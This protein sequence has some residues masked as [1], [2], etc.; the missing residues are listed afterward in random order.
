[1]VLGIYLAASV[2]SAL[3]I[4]WT[5]EGFAALRWLWLLPVAFAG[6][7]VGLL[8]LTGV[9]VLIMAAVVDMKKP[10]EKDSP[11]YRFVIMAL[12]SLLV[13]LLGIRIH[14][15]GME[16]APKG[17]RFL[18]VCNHLH[19][20][21]PAILLR[22]FPKCTLAFISKREV[23]GMFLVGPFL[24]KILGQAV[25]RENDREALKTILRCIDLIKEDVASVAVFPEGYIKQDRLLRT[26]RHGVFK[27]AQR[28]KVPVVVCTLRNTQ[29]AVKNA[30]KLKPTDIHLHLV[31][32]IYPEQ[33]QGMTTVD[34]GQMAYT[35]MVEDLGPE[36]VWQG[37]N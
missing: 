36:L 9:L 37:E 5:A 11:V 28:T 35:M 16:K 29:Y 24:H 26:F 6:T 13:P 1:M 19:E 4:C 12:I 30:M 23:D 33:M 31:G 8:L 20:I 15:E 21:D 22:A 2:L 14:E 34:L 18:L 32:V 7:F 10:Q 3:G 17:G 25:N 27:I